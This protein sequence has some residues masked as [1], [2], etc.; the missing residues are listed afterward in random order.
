MS[1]EVAVTLVVAWAPH[2]GSP[3]TTNLLPISHNFLLLSVYSCTTPT[4]QAVLLECLIRQV[5]HMGIIGTLFHCYFTL[6]GNKLRET[7]IKSTTEE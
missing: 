6:V 3:G 4:A 2:E 1:L 7:V 5:C